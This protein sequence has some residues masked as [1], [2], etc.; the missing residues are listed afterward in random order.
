MSKMEYTEFIKEAHDYGKTKVCTKCASRKSLSEF[1]NNES[2]D[3]L[4][5]ECKSCKK[6]YRDNMCPYKNWFHKKKSRAKI[7]GIE[8]TIKP[9]DIPGVK[10]REVITKGIGENKYGS[11]NRKYK[12]WEATEYPKV[13]TVLG[14]KL[15]WDMNGCNNN[16]PSLDRVNPKLGYIKGNVIMMSNL[17]NKMKNNA[18]PEE[19]KQFSEYHL[20]HQQLDTNPNQIGL[21]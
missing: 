18:T 14:I 11:F 9:T 19:L 8:F 17:A 4:K 12:S 3:G 6:I 16:S 10:I 1:Y 2:K 7:S 5:A 13:C 20:S 15:D 21:F